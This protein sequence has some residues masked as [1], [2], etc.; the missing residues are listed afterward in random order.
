MKNSIALFTFLAA[1]SVAIADSPPQVTEANGPVESAVPGDQ[2]VSRVA[3]DVEPVTVTS[4]RP[5]SRDIASGFVDFRSARPRT[6]TAPL[7]FDLVTEPVLL[8]VGTG[9]TEELHRIRIQF[10]FENVQDSTVR[11]SDVLKIRLARF[12]TP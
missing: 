7:A 1:S 10:P 4:N 3:P 11:N 8:T 2:S 12:V 9:N 5:R 6:L